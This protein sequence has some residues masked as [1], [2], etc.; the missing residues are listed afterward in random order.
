MFSKI[1]F[2]VERLPRRHR[3]L[4]CLYVKSYLSWKE[5]LIWALS[6]NKNDDKM[7]V[8]LLANIIQFVTILDAFRQII[9]KNLT[10]IYINTAV[11]SIETVD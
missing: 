9:M 8:F 5:W 1:I 7:I 4:M 2:H 10:S 11:F 6:K 3:S